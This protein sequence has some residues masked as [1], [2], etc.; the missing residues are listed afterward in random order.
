[1]S[2]SDLSPKE[3][4]DDAEEQKDGFLNVKTGEYA[5]QTTVYSFLLLISGIGFIIGALIAGVL[6]SGTLCVFETMSTFTGSIAAGGGAAGSGG[7]L[8]SA[9][10]QYMTCLKTSVYN[11]LA[12]L[13][14][15][16]GG[17]LSGYPSYKLAKMVA[18]GKHLRTII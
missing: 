3:S 4:V 12:L 9:E 6:V 10:A 18:S 11:P 5:S 16:I 1:M 15:L 2:D 7:I 14:A 17:I 13:S 8:E